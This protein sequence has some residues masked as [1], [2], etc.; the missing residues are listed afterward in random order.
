[1]KTKFDMF[2]YAFVIMILTACICA[3]IIVFME[4]RNEDE[5]NCV[6]FYKENHY[7]LES[8]KVYK[9]KLENID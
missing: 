5:E 1:M 6:N 7:I 4:C 9:D 3:I 8:C 2:D